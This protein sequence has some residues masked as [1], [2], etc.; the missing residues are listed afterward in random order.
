M[1]HALA[2][3]PDTRQRITRALFHMAVAGDAPD[4]EAEA[5]MFWVDDALDLAEGGYH[6]DPDTIQIQLSEFLDRHA[7]P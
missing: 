2:E 5:F 3:D 7:A 1:S 4:K 6:G